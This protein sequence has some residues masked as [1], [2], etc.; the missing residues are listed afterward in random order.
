MTIRQSTDADLV[1]I[2]DWLQR[3]AA[4]EGNTFH[5]N[6]GLIAKGHEA[7]ELY[8]LETEAQLAAFALGAPGVIDIF[9]TRPGLR[10]KGYG[11]QLAQFCI[12]RAAAADMAVIEGECAPETSLPFWEAMGFE[13][14]RPRYGDN[15]WVSLRVGKTNILPPGAPVDVVVRTFS[16]QVLYSD[17]VAAIGTYRP[18]AVK[19]ADGLIYL[20]KR[21]VLHEPNLANGRDLVIE[22]EVD[23]RC[24]ARDKA[25]RA[26][27]AAIGVRHDRFQQYYVDRIDPAGDAED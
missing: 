7:G 8:V 27:L 23:G 15:P 20:A 16:E 24:I 9:E 25:K 11:R 13:Q 4:E 2:L 12:D 22:I 26:K 3:E 14:I 6:R 5:S 1:D 21:I 18:T 10:G 17:G 19:A